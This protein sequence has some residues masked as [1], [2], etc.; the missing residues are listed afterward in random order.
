MPFDHYTYRVTWSAE[1]EEYV[2]LCAEF[3]S[4]L[5]LAEDQVEAL[6]GVRKLVADVVQDMRAS[7]EKIPEAFA[8]QKFSGKFQVRIPPEQHRAL[9]LEAAEQHVS[10]NRLVSSRL[11]VA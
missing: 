2:G 9:A 7:G 4:L 1:D 10:L 11:K 8:D 6:K 3:P 5:W